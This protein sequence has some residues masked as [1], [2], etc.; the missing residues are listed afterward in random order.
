MALAAPH[1]SW[2]LPVVKDPGTR[3]EPPRPPI[4]AGELLVRLRPDFPACA[5]CLL[6]KGAGF[7]SVTGTSVLDQVR[8][9]H[10]IT[11]M[12]PVFGGVH[13]AER[14]SQAAQ[15]FGSYQPSAIA[16][17]PIEQ[18]Y[19][20]RVDPKTDVLAVAADFRRDPNV[21]SAEPN[22][23][24]NAV[25][26]RQTA[27]GSAVGATHASS[28]PRPLGEGQARPEPS[29][30][31]EGSSLPNDPFLNSSGSWGQDFPDL[32]GLFQIH[33]PEAWALTQGEGVIVA[34]VD[35]G[36][37]I[38]H[39]DLAANVW[40][41]AAE[42]PGNG[43]DDDGNG[44][45]DDADG[46][47]F[48]QCVLLDS[49][50]FCRQPK[51]P[52]AD[53][54]D[55]V[56]HGTHVAGT[57]AAVGDNGVGIIGVAPQAQ[58]M[59]VKA[60]DRSG[61]GTNQDLAAAIVYA[62]ENG[63]KV[64]NASWAGP[65]SDTI[66]MAIDYVTQTFDVI[67]IAA[68]G[69]G[70]VP[71]EQGVYPANLP[72]VIAV[73]ATTHADE[74]ASFSNFGGPLDLV[75]PGGGDTE[76]AAA[77][78]PQQSILSL[79]AKDSDL[80]TS[81]R[82]EC[83]CRDPECCADPE[84]DFEVCQTVC[85][86]AAWVVDDQY[87]RL[88]GTSQA[89]P[90]VSAVAAL[91]RSRHPEFTREQ[92]RQVLVSTA[93]D[94][95]PAGWDLNFGY[96][97]VNA[98]NAVTIDTTPVAQILT[99]ENRGKI[100][101]RDFP[102]TVVGTVAAPGSTVRDWHLTVQRE[103]G[104]A[105]MEIGAGA[106]PVSNEPL[107]MLTLDGSGLELGRRYVLRLGATDAEGN[108]GVDAKTF[109]IPDPKFAIIPV[110][111]RYDEAGQDEAMSGDG[112]RVAL[113]RFDFSR[114]SFSFV[115]LYDALTR[116]LKR[117]GSGGP[118][119]LSGDGRT[120]VYSA[121]EGFVPPA[122]LFHVD[123]NTYD[124][125]P[126]GVLA[127]PTDLHGNRI[128]FLSQYDP[129]G[130]NPDR[131]VEAFLYDVG[132]GRVR[133]L[134]HVHPPGPIDPLPVINDLQIS[135]DGKRI[136]LTSN[137]PVAPNSTTRGS[138]QLFLYDD[139][140]ETIR[141]LT[142]PLQ[143]RTDR[144]GVMIEVERPTLSADGTVAAYV[145]EEYAP[146]SYAQEIFV[147][148]TTSGDTQ[149]AVN[150]GRFPSLPHL[151]ADGSRLA[152]ASAADLDGAVT[153]EDLNREVFVVNRNTGTTTQVTDS[154]NS[155]GPG[156]VAISD[157]GNT[158]LLESAGVT[159]EGRLFPHVARAVPRRRG[160]HPPVLQVPGMLTA[161][162]GQTLRVIFSASDPDGDPVTL[163]VG[164]DQ[165]SA[166]LNEFSSDFS[167]FGTGTA[168]LSLTFRHDQ[169]GEYILRVAAFDDAGAFDTKDVRLVVEDTQPEGDANCDGT[170]GA[171]DVTALIDA[172]F[173]PMPLD[174]CVSADTSD[175]GRLAVNDLTALM[176]K[177]VR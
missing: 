114:N 54:R 44:F 24:Y 33:A 130:E 134:T 69:N 53:V 74:R 50:G 108:V 6:E 143:T 158:I 34:V 5:H 93:D 142:S 148:D 172:L 156:P 94:L 57:I 90:H 8:L 29:R 23:I 30:R 2:S 82:E 37:D 118:P 14:R 96:G 67:V 95:G 56:G 146:G 173:E 88:G 147:V 170:L 174:R 68:A 110:P 22:Y 136:L 38:T 47:D 52:G 31:G 141:Q 151:S 177:L 65:Q 21:V 163:Y 97:R 112:T 175:D 162:E 155:F 150:G 128:A 49:S 91:A 35:T 61:Q 171:D 126:E 160:N 76:P 72:N 25:G 98:A 120:L 84:C 159:N 86:P 132:T 62:G 11:R 79:W 149:P 125:Q 145:A 32:W 58:V 105:T 117:V 116:T 9:K 166:A 12:D 20:V 89:A 122:V 10:G 27:V 113:E 168:Q 7:K 75:A 124:V 73:G 19:L 46:W 123:M 71:L 169:A 139:T 144:S 15:R 153:N 26:S 78:E 121:I 1:S 104:G 131:S 36:I 40:H 87:V 45:I 103:D 140:V 92:V 107:G 42:I 85:G 127:G 41:N 137:V 164:R 81:C 80:G 55:P 115:W 176:I 109:L 77:V 167:D 18:T 100:F 152:F 60:I 102:F 13:A 154:I 101:E 135:Q 119:H 17:Q 48:T 59:A 83:H 161:M 51:A 66:T 64:I 39:P 3:R 63:A 165:R 70:G 4:V 157:D 99:P 111:D 138:R 106:A 16:H 43:I 133:Q 129:V 28:S